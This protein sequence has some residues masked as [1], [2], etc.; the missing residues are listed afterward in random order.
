LEVPLD[1]SNP[2]GD[3][4]KLAVLK[5]PAINPASTFKGAFFIN[6]D[7]LNN[8]DFSDSGNA[9]AFQLGGFDGFDFY[10]FDTRG[11]GHS[12]PQLSCFPDQKSFYA[13]SLQVYDN[14][15]VFGAFNGT[16]PPTEAN[17]KSN[18]QTINPFMSQFGNGCVQNYGKYLP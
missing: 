7:F 17:I 4:F 1:Y 2:N 8:V 18:I 12:T 6:Q 3:I 13:Y 16:F 11:T 9:A 14:D 15:N 5:V 10:A